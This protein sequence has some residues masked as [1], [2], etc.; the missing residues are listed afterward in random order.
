MV[1]VVD[2]KSDR[3]DFDFFSEGIG[4]V[5]RILS[6]I[7]V[8]V[9]MSVCISFEA[10]IISAFTSFVIPSLLD[11]VNIVSSNSSYGEKN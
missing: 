8:V 9:K 11:I 4:V 5:N 7:E 6:G 10:V 2:L 1:D 3:I